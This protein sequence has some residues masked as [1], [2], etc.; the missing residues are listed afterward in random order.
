[1][2][3]MVD[4]R[5]RLVTMFGGRLPAAVVGVV[6]TGVVGYLSL[7]VLSDAATLAPDAG[8]PLFR[9]ASQFEAGLMVAFIL[10]L[11]ATPPA[12]LFLRPGR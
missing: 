12:Y 5:R 1:M 4:L 7:F 11:V 8:E 2:A 10:L 9:G 6:T 3:C